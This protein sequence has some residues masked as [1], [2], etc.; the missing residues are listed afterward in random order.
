[1]WLDR[2][3]PRPFAHLARA[4][5]WAEGTTREDPP[6]IAATADAIE[7]D[8]AAGSTA[9]ITLLDLVTELIATGASD[10]EVATA[11]MDLLQTGRVRLIGQ[12]CDED[13]P[14]H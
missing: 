4:L 6:M 3:S 7:R 5:H 8:A 11:V 13:L 14:L 1:M 9:V 10:R 2:G 12:V